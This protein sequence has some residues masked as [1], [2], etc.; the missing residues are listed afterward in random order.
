MIFDSNDQ[1]QLLMQIVD[2]T[3]LQSTGETIAQVAN[4]IQALRIAISNGEIQEVELEL[5]ADEAEG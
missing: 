5:I 1:K 2:K 4:E 3:G